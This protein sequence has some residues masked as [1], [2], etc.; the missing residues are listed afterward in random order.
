MK[1]KIDHY[2]EKEMAPL[3]PTDRGNKRDLDTFFPFKAPKIDLKCS[4]TLCNFFGFVIRN[5]LHDNIGFVIF[6]LCVGLGIK[7]QLDSNIKVH[8][9]G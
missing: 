4:K 1:Q 8:S 2:G 6:C 3:S 5:L 9:C 7:T